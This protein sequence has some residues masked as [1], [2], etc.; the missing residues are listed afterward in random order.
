MSRRKQASL[1]ELRVGIFVV[2]SCALLAVAIFLIGS[3]VGLFQE[4][5]WAMTYLSNVSGLKPGDIVLLGGVEVGNVAKVQIAPTL[6]P[7]ETDQNRRV[8]RRVAE[9]EKIRSGIEQKIASAEEDLAAAREE[10]RRV[11][12]ELGSESSKALQLKK[13]VEALTDTLTD[14]QEDLDDMDRRIGDAR[15]RFQNILVEVRI[16]SEYRNW[17][18]RDSNISLGSIGLLGDK[19]IEISL[20][21]TADLPEVRDVPIKGILGTTTRETVVITGTQQASFGE[22]ITGANDILANFETLSDQ[23]LGIMRSFEAGQGTV[24]KFITDPSFFNNLNSTVENANR[25]MERIRSLVENVGEG[26]G[27]I[28]KLM[29]ED[30]VYERI[31]SA[32]DHLNRLL[33]KIE[34][35][36]GTL[37]KLVNDPS[38]YDESAKVVGDIGEITGRIRDG[39]G[40]LGKL[41][42]DDQVYVSL[43][44]SLDELAALLKDVEQGKGTLGKLVKDEQLYNNL[45]EVS[46]EIVKLIYDFRQNP[47]KFL[48]IQFKIF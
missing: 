11:E 12:A 16:N 15:S 7:P 17:I 39:E 8:H 38:I 42:T 30:E 36:D 31:K 19:Y 45:N 2:V 32:T 43:Q 35:G 20:G 46:A 25:M 21:R 6:D 33:Q 23:V 13:V 29:R 40:T 22:L 18:R 3:Q 9:L 1:T 4:Q 5:F 34:E 44:K 10:Y 48:T 26:G 27:T 47:K 28:S 14:R 37:G 41:A 24:G